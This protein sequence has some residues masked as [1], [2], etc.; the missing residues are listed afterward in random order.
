M[1]VSATYSPAQYDCDSITTDFTFSF[2]VV[3]SADVEVILTSSTG[4]ETVLTETTHYSVTPAG[5]GYSAGG[6]VTTVATYSSLERLTIRRNIAIEQESVFSEGMP[7]LYSTF[8][9]TLDYLTMICQ[10]LD[11]QSGRSIML[12]RSSEYSNLSFPEP[13]A[14]SY[15]KTK[16]DLSGYENVNLFTAVATSTADG[17]Y[18]STMT[19]NETVTVDTEDGYF[20]TCILDPN[21]GDRNFTLNTS[22][23]L[24]AVIHNK[25]PYLI[26]F[27]PTGIA[28]SIGANDSRVFVYDSTGTCWY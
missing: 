28:Q 27:D 22:T 25:G 16:S 3:S 6:T 19:A 11:E 21:G 14:G 2:G 10:Q 23:S 24:T 5:S 4:V 26:T 7:T 1:T 12:T 15:L 9:D 20:F 17:F 18:T 13:V 8:E